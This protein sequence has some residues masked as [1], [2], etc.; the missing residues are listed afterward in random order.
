MDPHLCQSTNET[1]SIP[2][3]AICYLAGVVNNLFDKKRHVFMT[4]MQIFFV[5]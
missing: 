2:H 5:I 4:I 3:V 1:G